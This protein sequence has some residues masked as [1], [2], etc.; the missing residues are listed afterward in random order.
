MFSSN[1]KCISKQKART[2]YK[3]LN[4][5]QG[6]QWKYELEYSYS[7]PFFVFCLIRYFIPLR[8]QITCNVSATFT[9]SY[10]RW[11]VPKTVREPFYAGIQVISSDRLI[12]KLPC[13]VEID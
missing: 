11:S 4:R 9:T 6:C 5:V 2:K 1:A 7:N 3:L 8:Q 13:N 10:K 12:S